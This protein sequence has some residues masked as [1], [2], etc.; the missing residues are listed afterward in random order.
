MDPPP[1][2]I[3]TDLQ[4][5]FHGVL[6]VISY[7]SKERL[8]KTEVIKKYIIDPVNKKRAELRKDKSTEPEIILITEIV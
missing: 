8:L 3:P 7:Q 6:P 4:K 5:S 2:A 1:F